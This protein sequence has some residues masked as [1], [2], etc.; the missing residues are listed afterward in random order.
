[1]QL[2]QNIKDV[3]SMAADL[4]LDLKA[5]WC[6]QSSIARVS[7]TRTYKNRRMSLGA[8]N[9]FVYEMSWSRAN[10][11]EEQADADD[12]SDGGRRRRRWRRRR[13]W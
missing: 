12:A 1:M 5:L 4:D 10:Q 11:D 7:Y 13:W 8:L 2:E 6:A 9:D 3:R